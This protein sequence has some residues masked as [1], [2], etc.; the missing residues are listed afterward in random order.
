MLQGLTYCRNLSAPD[1]QLFKYTCFSGDVMKE[2]VLLSGSTYK[3]TP[4]KTTDNIT[5]EG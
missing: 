2:L 5:Q 3:I 1:F 4:Q